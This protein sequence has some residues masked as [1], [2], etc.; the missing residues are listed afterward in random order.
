MMGGETVPRERMGNWFQNCETVERSLLG[1][2]KT[3]VMKWG[4]IPVW[5]VSSGGLYGDTC[6]WTFRFVRKSGGVGLGQ[7]HCDVFVVLG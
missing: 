2:R 3:P 4:P 6:V 1:R 7:T 5:R